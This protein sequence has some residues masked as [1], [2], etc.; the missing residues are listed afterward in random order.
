MAPVKMAT[1]RPLKAA[2]TTRVI[3]RA[4]FKPRF[5]GGLIGFVAATTVMCVGHLSTQMEAG[6]TTHAE[7]SPIKAVAREIRLSTAKMAK[8]KAA[9]AADRAAVGMRLGAT[10]TVERAA[11]TLQVSTPSHAKRMR[12]VN[13]IVRGFRA[14]AMAAAEAVESALK[15]KP[16]MVL[17]SVPRRA[18]P[19]VKG[20]RA[21]LMAVAE[22]VA[23][24]GKMRAVTLV[25]V[26]R[27]PALAET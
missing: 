16:V 20:S 17:V 13:Q 14:A 25:S 19:R 7:T 15:A 9:I 27:L 5:V 23:H 3:R 6:L 24:V 2:M 21:G 10:T 4:L 22:A 18:S 11:A 8:S 26:S 12:P 1:V